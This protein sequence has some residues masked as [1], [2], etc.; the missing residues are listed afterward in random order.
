MNFA[1][2]KKNV[3]NTSKALYFLKLFLNFLN[4][5]LSIINIFN[6]NIIFF[7]KIEK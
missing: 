4:L 1:P 7:E 5:L 3:K 6:R 2:Q